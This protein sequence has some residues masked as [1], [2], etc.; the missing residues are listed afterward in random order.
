[1]NSTI[2]NVQSIISSSGEVISFLSFNEH[3]WDQVEQLVRS[4]A[5]PNDDPG[6]ITRFAAG[7]I[8]PRIVKLKLSRADAF[9]AAASCDWTDLL[10]RST[11]LCD[12]LFRGGG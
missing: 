4:G 5:I 8:S 9:G 11:E 10:Q 6:L 12:E 2:R 1:M 3:G 7:V